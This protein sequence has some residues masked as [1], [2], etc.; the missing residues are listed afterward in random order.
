MTLPDFIQ[1]ESELTFTII[2]L[3]LLLG[4]WILFRLGTRLLG[5]GLGAGFGFFIG[6]VLN[7]VLKIDRNVGLY[8]TIGCSMIGALAAIFMLRAVANFLFALIGFLFGALAGR[9]AAEVYADWHN[10]P[11]ALNGQAAMIILPA[12]GITALLAVWLQRLIMILITSYMG[13]TFLVAGVDYLTRQ[14]LAFPL[15]LVAGI[16]W[17]SFIL[18]K[19]FK[20]SKQTPP[21]RKRLAPVQED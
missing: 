12:A 10:L 5:V 6:E 19:I 16:F 2:G 18:G 14:P 20:R 13:A 11:F 17:Q 1:S 8:V 4:G 3:A 9:I 21:P 7:I 15:V